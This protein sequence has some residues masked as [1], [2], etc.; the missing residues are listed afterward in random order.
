MKKF[1][2]FSKTSIYVY[3]LFI[4]SSN[5]AIGNTFSLGLATNI[6]THHYNDEDNYDSL[7]SSRDYFNSILL[8]TKFDTFINLGLYARFESIDFEMVEERQRI[9]Y[10]LGVEMNKTAYSGGVSLGFDLYNF[11]LDFLLGAGRVNLSCS[12]NS[13]EEV[14]TK[15]DSSSEASLDLGLAF[16]WKFIDNFSVDA[17]M[18]SSSSG[19]NLLITDND[20]RF[21]VNFS[22]INWM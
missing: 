11:Y 17:L 5:M 3:V 15:Q 6:Y 19:S 14:F 7:D 21:Y 20:N 10:E 1:I 16:S 22:N 12:N 2:K 13:C 8:Q 4:L 18:I 9:L